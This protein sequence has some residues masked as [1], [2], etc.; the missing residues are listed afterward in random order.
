MKKKEFLTEAKRKAIIAD[1]EKV[2]IESFAKMFNRIKRIDENEIN[3]DMNYIKN[4]IDNHTSPFFDFKTNKVIFEIEDLDSVLVYDIVDYTPERPS[5]NPEEDV[6]GEI[7]LNF[8]EA[9]S[10]LANGIDDYIDYVE[11]T[12]THGK[13]QAEFWEEFFATR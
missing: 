9:E 7:V 13:H 5:S 1:K 12:V 4:I 10:T 3:G 6:D 2:V 11:E 8:N